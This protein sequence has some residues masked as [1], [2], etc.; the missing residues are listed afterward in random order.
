[1]VGESDL[2]SAGFGAWSDSHQD[3]TLYVLSG[4]KQWTEEVS[5]GNASDNTYRQFFRP[6]WAHRLTTGLWRADT[7]SP[8]EGSGSYTGFLT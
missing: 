6:F 8:T 5:V 7:R 3:T 1:M 2:L 4:K